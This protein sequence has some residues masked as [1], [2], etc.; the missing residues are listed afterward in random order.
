MRWGAARALAPALALAAGEARADPP[1]RGFR[2]RDFAL[3]GGYGAAIT[4][5]VGLLRGDPFA[6][7]VAWGRTWSAGVDLRFYQGGGEGLVARALYLEV[8]GCGPPAS[9]A[10]GAL[11]ELG[12][13]YRF[14]LAQSR[15]ATLLGHGAV[16]LSGMIA[17]GSLGARRGVGVASGAFVT[18]G[19]DV[20]VLGRVVLGVALDARYLGATLLPHAP[21]W[22]EG[23]A[24]LRAGVD[25]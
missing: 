21:S 16:G 1:V 17:E 4:Y 19:A 8:E 13:A 9:R 15:S 10:R 11:L 18:V 14:T 20:R 25:F 7:D 2:L 3:V 12:A 22:V 24:R 5:S 23:V 6:V